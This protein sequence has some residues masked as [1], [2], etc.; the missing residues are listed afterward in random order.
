MTLAAYHGDE[1]RNGGCLGREV[2]AVRSLEHVTG[3][4][5][6]PHR[7][8]WNTPPASLEAGKQALL[9]TERDDTDP[10]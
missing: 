9:A 5:Q 8:N 1:R 7:R 6:P 4:E 10:D 2:S 3:T